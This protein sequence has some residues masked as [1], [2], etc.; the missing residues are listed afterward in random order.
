M[1]RLHRTEVEVL[2]K[3]L[4]GATAAILDRNADPERLSTR[5]WDRLYEAFVDIPVCVDMPLGELLNPDL[6]ILPAIWDSQGRLHIYSFEALSQ[7]LREVRFST[8]A[9]EG[10]CWVEMNLMEAL[11]LIGAVS[12]YRISIRVS[13]RQIACYL[14]QS[15]SRA[16]EEETDEENSDVDETT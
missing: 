14:K 7:L 16:L 3:L 5:E 8:S 15:S 6:W 11:N 13:R 12:I 4:Q 9:V 10:A 2:C 1:Q